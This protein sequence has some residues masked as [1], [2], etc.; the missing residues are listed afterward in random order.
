MIK[1]ILIITFHTL[2][3]ILILKPKMKSIYKIALFVLKVLFV[4]SG[5]KGLQK[6]SRTLEYRVCLES[7]LCFNVSSC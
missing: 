1:H 5:N 4:Y 6:F 3:C 2:N 7:G